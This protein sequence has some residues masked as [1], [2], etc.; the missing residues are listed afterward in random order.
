[1]T[2]MLCLSWRSGDEMIDGGHMIVPSMGQAMR[3]STMVVAA[4]AIDRS[5]MVHIDPIT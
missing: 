4:S 1:M 3:S 5:D 2:M